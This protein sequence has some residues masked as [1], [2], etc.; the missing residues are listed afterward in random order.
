MSSAVLLMLTN[1][2]KCIGLWVTGI[3]AKMISRG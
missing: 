3:C 1:T 2:S